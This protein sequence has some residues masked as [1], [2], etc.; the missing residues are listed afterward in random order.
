MLGKDEALAQE[1]GLDWYD[2]SAKKKKYYI[3]YLVMEDLDISCN[4]TTLPLNP[5]IEFS[6]I[7]KM[8]EV[9]KFPMDIGINEEGYI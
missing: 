3:Q 8:E 7:Q 2:L 6:A 5:F 4:P 1:V 9:D